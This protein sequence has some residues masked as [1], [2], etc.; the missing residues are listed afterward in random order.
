MSLS[1]WMLLAFATWTL[2]LL[3]ATIGVYRWSHI[4]MGRTGGDQRH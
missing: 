1:A 3:M 2:L 4:L